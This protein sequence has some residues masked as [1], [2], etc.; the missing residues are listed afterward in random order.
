M[1]F[2]DSG[3]LILNHTYFFILLE[4]EKKSSVPESFVELIKPV[5]GA[6]LDLFLKELDT[7]PTVS[8]RINPTKYQS[9][10][11]TDR[12]PW[13]ANGRYLSERP[14]FTLDPSLHAGAYYVQ[15]S[16]SM[17]LEQV[18]KATVDLSKPL[19]VLDL[20]AAPGGKSTHLLSMLSS[21]ALLV[22]NEVIKSRASILSENLQKWGYPNA[23]VT[24]N[25]PSDFSKLSGFFDL[26]VV[27]APCSGEGLFR[28]DLEAVKHW[29]KENVELCALRQQRILSDVWPSLKTGGTL[30]YSTCTYNQVEDENVLNEFQRKHDVEFQ[31]IALEDT[32]GIQEYNHQGVVGYRLLPHKVRGEG[33]FISSFKKLENQDS[34]QLKTRRTLEPASSDTIAKISKWLREPDSYAFISLDDLVIA[35]THSHLHEIGFLNSHLRLINKGIA[36]ARDKHGKLVPEHAAALSTY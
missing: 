1:W 24:Q 22:S 35:I 19:R 2:I 36:L 14:S 31:T 27:D 16:S 21:E 7:E 30:V 6:E 9:S 15:E 28:K 8:V 25:D 12:V 23:V 20:C 34:L 5:I 33:F 13:A 10:D 11:L 29:S 32:W 4:V 18:V 17:F 3:H 26:I